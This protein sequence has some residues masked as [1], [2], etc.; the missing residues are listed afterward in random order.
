M[1]RTGT[2]EK[3]VVTSEMNENIYGSYVHG[4]FDEGIIAKRQRTVDSY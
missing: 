2:E 4:L 3:A 1:G